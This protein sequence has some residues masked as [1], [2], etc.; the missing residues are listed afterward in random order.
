MISAS[1]SRSPPRKRDSRPAGTEAAN[2]EKTGNSDRKI[3]SITSPRAQH[4]AP[5]F[6]T[7]PLARIGEFVLLDWRRCIPPATGRVGI[8]TVLLPSGK[9]GG[10]AIYNLGQQFAEWWPTSGLGRVSRRDHRELNAALPFTVALV[11]KHDP[12]AL[13]EVTLLPRRGGDR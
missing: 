9:L 13:R 7:A 11:R 3:N 1:R 2:L 8:A 10:F 6:T 12:D 4:Q 5:G